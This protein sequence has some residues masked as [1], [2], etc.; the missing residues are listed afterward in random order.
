MLARM[1]WNF[2]FEFPGGEE[3]MKQRRLKPW[4]AQKTFALWVKEDL[5]LKFTP[6]EH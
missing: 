6:V 4:V 1:V 5:V 3:E 2:D